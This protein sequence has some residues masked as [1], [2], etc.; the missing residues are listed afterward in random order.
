M[1]RVR[2]RPGL[3]SGIVL[4]VVTT[5]VTAITL[6]IGA[7]WSQWL[8]IAS[9]VLLAEGILV[10]VLAYRGPGVPRTRVWP[11]TTDA[12]YVFEEEWRQRPEPAGRIKRSML[13]MALPPLVLG[14]IFFVLTAW[15]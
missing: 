10:A 2:S 1:E 6:V 11:P 8:G 5:A 14:A 7:S 4:A 3:G 13:R 15:G 9:L 12:A